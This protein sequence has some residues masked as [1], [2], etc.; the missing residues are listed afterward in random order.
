M[1]IV[2]DSIGVVDRC[3]VDVNNY[4]YKELFSV[5]RGCFDPYS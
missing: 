5:S 4:R 2:E 3:Y 1:L